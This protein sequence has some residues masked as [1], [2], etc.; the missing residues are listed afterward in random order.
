MVEMAAKLLV[1]RNI[2]F[3]L[4]FFAFL[5]VFLFVLIRNSKSIKVETGFVKRGTITSFIS[6]PGNVRPETE[7]QVSSDVSGRVVSLPV[8]EGQKIQKG[9]LLVQI[10]SSSYQAQA[11]QSRANL[12]Q[13][14]AS[15][16]QSSSQWERTKELYKSKLISTQEMENSRA[17]YQLDLARTR[18]AKAA[19]DEAIDQLNE[20]TIRAP[21]NGT[22]T[23]LDIESGEIVV[24][25]TMNFAGTV[26]M[27]IA[28]LSQMRIECDV[29]E[30]DISSVH[31]GKKAKIT[32]D[33]FP[34]TVFDGTVT[35]V[36]N[37]RSIQQ[38]QTTSSQASSG[39]ASSAQTNPAVSYTVK[40]DINNYKGHLKPDMTVNVDII[41]A[42][43]QNALIIPVQAIIPRPID[44]SNSSA[45]SSNS[46]RP[47]YDVYTVDKNTA[48]LQS[49]ITGIFGEDDVEIIKGLSE[50]Q[51]I[52]T[53]PFSTLRLLKDGIRIKK[54]KNP[55]DSTLKK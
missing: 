18:Q 15:L 3:S 28:D 45:N 13:A 46:K 12:D 17:Q 1:R 42:S 20:T 31:P 38:D 33:A 19:L 14:R 24:T 4:I 30:A 9:Q 2:I 50:G 22:I 35:E 47:S 49:V 36:G 29:D 23:R 5:A 43:K 21:I 48:R 40:V 27:I 53:G 7:V 34:D 44:N 32:I 54:I 10:D 25:G 39:T 37:A 52:I 26:L 16:N 55:S 41:T 6:A 11:N 8:K 51:E